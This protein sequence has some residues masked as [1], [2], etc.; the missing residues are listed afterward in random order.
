MNF[1]IQSIHFRVGEQRKTSKENVFRLKGR[2]RPADCS[3]VNI[4]PTVFAQS[5]VIRTTPSSLGHIPRKSTVFW[6]NFTTKST[7]LASCHFYLREITNKVYVILQS[8]RR[9]C[10]DKGSAKALLT[11]STRKDHSLA[12]GDKVNSG[13]SAS[14]G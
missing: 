12:S 1:K 6:K 8:H 5:I 4:F 7:W 10:W 11:R 3:I 9:W 2:Y 13:K 14:I